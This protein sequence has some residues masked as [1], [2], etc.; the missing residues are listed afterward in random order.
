MAWTRNTGG[1]F[2]G[3]RNGDS[4]CRQCQ[5]AMPTAKSGRQLTRSVGSAA[6]GSP[7]SKFAGKYG[8]RPERTTGYSQLF[9]TYTETLDPMPEGG[10]GR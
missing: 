2:V 6:F 3:N 5:V 7:A 8:P 1:A 4:F 10:G 9:R